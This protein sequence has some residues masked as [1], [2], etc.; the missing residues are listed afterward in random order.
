M[1]RRGALGVR[2]A[3]RIDISPRV[4]PGLAVWPGD[5]AY[6]RRVALDV[7]EGDHLTLSSITTTV[8]LGAHADAPNHYA[9]H[10]PGIGARDLAPYL[11]PCEVVRVDVERGERLRP[12]HLPGP[13]TARRVLFHTGTFPDPDDWNE[14]FAALSPEL[15]HHLADAGVVLV[16]IDTP[17]VDLM[18]DR[19]LLAHHAIAERDL[20]ILEG[21]VLTA[22]TPGAYTLVA[23]PLP[24]AGADASPVRAVLVDGPLDALD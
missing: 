21:L 18:H 14:D 6:Q 17:S 19:A 20:C 15:V 16:G 12:E 24:L 22:V 10:A 4:H 9:V 3:R 5:V 7:D 2:M 1:G 8:H 13:V 23:L 11:G